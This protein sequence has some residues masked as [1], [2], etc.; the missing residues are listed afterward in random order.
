MSLMSSHLSKLLDRRTSPYYLHENVFLNSRGRVL[1]KK[2]LDRETTEFY[3]LRIE[4]S[5]GKHVGIQIPMLYSKY[6]P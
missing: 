1:I 5:D 6:I 3:K 4:V 2:P